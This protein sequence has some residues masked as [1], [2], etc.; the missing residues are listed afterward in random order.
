MTGMNDSGIRGVGDFIKSVGFPVAAYVALFLLLVGALPSMLTRQHDEILE[1]L[2]YN[3]AVII[4]NFYSNHALCLN[5]AE[6]NSDNLNPQQVEAWKQ[7]CARAKEQMEQH[8][9]TFRVPKG[10]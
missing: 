8:L 1:Y 3:Q 2:R 10:A 4:S 5:G 7:R 6:Q 9:L